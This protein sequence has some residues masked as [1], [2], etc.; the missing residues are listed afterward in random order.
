[1]VGNQRFLPQPRD[2][3]QFQI[4]D[5][6]SYYRN[7]ATYKVGFDYAHLDFKASLPLLF[8][9]LYRFGPLPAI[10]GV[11]PT[12]LTAEQAFGAGLPQVFAQ[13]FGAPD[14]E[15]SASWFG[16]F[17]QGEWTFKRLL[18]K[19]GL[20]YE[21]ESPLAP[22]PTDSN[23]WAPRFSFSYSGGENWRVRGGLGRFYG[24]S[25]AGPMFAVG[26][27]DG[28]TVK[29]L[30]RVLGVGPMSLWPTV[31]WNLPNRRFAD[32]TQA[33][34][35]VVPLTVLR[36]KG[37]ETATP[38]NL[39]IS[40]CAQFESAYTDQASLGFET[41]LMSKVLFNVDYLYA[42]GRK[43]FVT[44]NINPSIGGARR[45]NPA[46]GDIF[47]YS[48]TG[49]SWY[50]GVTAGL[51][52]RFG[53]AFEAA[54]YYTYASAEDDYIDWL[55]EFQLQDPRNPGDERGPSVHVP[56]HKATLSAIWRSPT[57]GPIW[58]RDW[59][60]ATIGELLV[61][62]PHNVLAGFDRNTN[63]DP[64]S[65]R[66]AGVDRNSGNLPTSLNFD[67]RVARR[68]PIGPVAF[69]ATFEVFNLFN[70]T[71]VL[72]VNEVFYTGTTL[73]LNPNY[74][75]PTRIAD[76]RRIQLGGRFTF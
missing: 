10:P 32:Q 65:D 38:P 47:L 29:T 35:S 27:Q 11:L 53:G 69:E 6:V 3:K 19:L 5:A 43:I 71:N 72:Q 63:G 59:T 33:G 34:T 21:R 25:S 30:V 64:L 2:S 56:K 61:G 15:G 73:A 12:P 57:T 24:I 51:Q 42:R 28:V 74:R 16:A 75:T 48:S 67:L 54:F 76:P 60:V 1:M 36:P 37:C 7:N 62:R 52:T 66:P 68:I 44:N 40:D 49:N 22:F 8:A 55:T 17:A 18:V 20:R 50:H 13:G 46:F 9:A 26:L 45:P 14:G 39:N 4:F 41:Q 70:R 58:A 31:P 23:N